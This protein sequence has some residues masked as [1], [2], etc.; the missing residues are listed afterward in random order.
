MGAKINTLAAAVVFLMS[1]HGQT[2]QYRLGTPFP[3]TCEGV[4]TYQ[5]GGYFLT[6]DETHLNSGSDHD[7]ICDGA[8]IAEETG[9][10]TTKYTLREKIIR[11]VLEACSLG[12]LCEIVGEMN[13][14]SHD[15]WFWVRITSVRSK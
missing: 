7:G 3:T 11:Q 6:H 1:S 12:H 13:G 15:V 2:A 8:T 10:S 9:H 5:E 14:I 4:L